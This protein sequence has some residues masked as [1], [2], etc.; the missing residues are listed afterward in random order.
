MSIWLRNRA[1]EI[2]YHR[3]PKIS[4]TRYDF[5]RCTGFPVPLFPR[6]LIVP[7]ARATEVAAALS[8]WPGF[9]LHPFLSPA[10]P[11]D[12]A[13][14]CAKLRAINVATS[15]FFVNSQAVCLSLPMI[16]SLRCLRNAK[17][18]SSSNSTENSSR[19]FS[20]SLTCRTPR[21]LPRSHVPSCP[22]FRIRAL[23][24]QVDLASRR[25]AGARRFNIPARNLTQMLGSK[26][27]IYGVYRR[28]LFV[29]L[30][31]L[32]PSRARSA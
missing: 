21:S 9:S 11:L 5:V 7:S 10:F 31:A 19:R 14:A 1:A 23:T 22:D 29:K 27:G 20:S 6:I 30:T 26:C 25:R 17:G 13:L 15:E 4:L 24:G 18:P 8:G 2:W 12:V 32:P 16:R 28:N 3:S